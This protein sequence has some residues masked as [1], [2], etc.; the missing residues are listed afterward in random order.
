MLVGAHARGIHADLTVDQAGCIRPR[1][2][3]GDH[4]RMSRRAASTGTTRRPSARA[5]RTRARHATAH[6]PAP[7][8]G[9]RRS[10]ATWSTSAD[11]PCTR[12]ATATPAPPTARQSDRT[13]SSPLRWPRGLRVQVLLSLNQLPETSSST[14]QRH[15][16]DRIQLRGLCRTLRCVVHRE[17]PSHHRQRA[18]GR[19]VTTQ[20]QPEG[21]L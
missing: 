12:R 17:S 8:T 5:R 11:D 7:A 6:R 3:R 21:L 14:D 19:D 18:T 2:Q 20:D 9:Y 1:Q 13:A 10:T 16:K 4:R 15:A